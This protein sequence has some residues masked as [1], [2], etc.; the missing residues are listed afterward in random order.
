MGNYIRGLCGYPEEYMGGAQVGRKMRDFLA[1]PEACVKEY[2]RDGFCVTLLNFIY[3]YVPREIMGMNVS[4]RKR[5]Y[6]VG[7]VCIIYKLLLNN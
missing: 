5:L 1:L 4:G 6:K 2:T 3:T 7:Y